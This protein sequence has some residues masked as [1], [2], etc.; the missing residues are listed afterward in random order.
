WRVL[1]AQSLRRTARMLERRAALEPVD[2][3]NLTRF[4][5]RYER[6]LIDSM[7]R[8][9]KVPDDVRSQAEVFFAN[10]EK[11]AGESGSD[12][13]P[14]GDGAVVFHRNPDVKGQM[15]VFGYDYLTDH[16]GDEKSNSIRLLKYQGL[17]GNGEEYAYEVLNFVDGRRSAQE[18]RDSVSAV[19]GPIP[20]E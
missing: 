13:P 9:F 17:R 1:Q 11:L 7:E 4:H 14:L 3:A 2:A 20:L 16:Y 19:Y 8:F 12:A 18:I 6:S 15:T 10:L 5:F